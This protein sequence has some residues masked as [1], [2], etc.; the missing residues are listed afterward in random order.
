MIKI[1]KKV[2]KNIIKENN[3]ATI[4]NHPERRLNASSDTNIIAIF[5]NSYFSWKN[6]SSS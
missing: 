1:I 6:I 4:H 2:I 5:N 3:L